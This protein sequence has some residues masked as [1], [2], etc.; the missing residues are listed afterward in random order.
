FVANITIG[1]NCM[2]APRCAFMPYQHN[3]ADTSRPMREQPL[4]SR[5]DI[6][7]EDDVWLGANAC[8]L[9]GVT[10]GRGAI[11]GAGAVVTKDVPSYAIAGGVPAHVIKFRENG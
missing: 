4:I 2:I 3:W 5:G 6:V 11:I 1:A 7:L 10:I 9:D 8:V